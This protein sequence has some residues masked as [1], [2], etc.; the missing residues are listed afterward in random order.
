MNCAAEYTDGVGGSET[1]SIGGTRHVKTGGDLV[2]E[3]KGTLTR[4]VSSLQCITG[5]AGVQRKVVGSSKTTVGAA[6]L[7]AAGGSRG[8]A[9]GGS[10]SETV[11]ALKLI[12]AKQM[13]LSCG[14]AYTANCGAYSVKCGTSRTDSATGA[15]SIAAGGGMSV[16]AT[17]INIEAQNKLVVIAAGCTIKLTKS[18]EVSIKAPSVDLTGVKALNQVMHKS[19]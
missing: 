7:E 5:I 6:W 3:T 19:N 15:V 16:K 10:R 18:G 4:T 12:K 17:K 9:C 13:S 8:S 11:G 2:E 14:A 1:L